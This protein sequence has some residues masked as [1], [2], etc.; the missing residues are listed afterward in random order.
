MTK[1]RMFYIAYRICDYM[2]NSEMQNQFEEYEFCMYVSDIANDI[3]YAIKSGEYDVL[4]PYYEALNYELN[5]VCWNEECVVEV[6]EMIELLDECKNTL[7]VY[8]TMI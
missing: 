6:K 3:D 5:N 1:E 2:R 8:K 4:K 7:Y